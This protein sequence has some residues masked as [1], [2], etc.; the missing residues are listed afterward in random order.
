[1]KVTQATRNGKSCVG[2]SARIERKGEQSSITITKVI[3]SSPAHRTG[4][5]LGDRML[6]LN[7]K[8]AEG[9]PNELQAWWVQK[10][11]NEQVTLLVARQGNAS[12]ASAQSSGK[13]NRQTNERDQQH[14]PHHRENGTNS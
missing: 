10:L 11:Q 9:N 8:I 3:E 1:M 2:C 6:R 12:T 5:H 14:M 13:R 4:L 7:G